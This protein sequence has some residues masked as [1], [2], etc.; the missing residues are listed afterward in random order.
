MAQ[1]RLDHEAVATEELA[2]GKQRVVSE[3]EGI[4]NLLALTQ[5]H[6]GLTSSG[7]VSLRLCYVPQLGCKIDVLSRVI[8]GG[9]ADGRR[10]VR[11]RKPNI[12]T[13]NVARRQSGSRPVA[14]DAHSILR[15]PGCATFHKPLL[16]K[17]F[18]HV[19]FFGQAEVDGLGFGYP[20]CQFP[21]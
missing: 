6:Y 12:D 5:A 3:N 16:E 14:G 21:R 7:P 18:D 10:H 11:A 13:L 2:E 9:R 4:G 1:E 20:L 15:A 19:T 17:I 8:Y